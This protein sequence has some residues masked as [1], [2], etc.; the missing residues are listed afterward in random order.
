MNYAHNGSEFRYSLKRSAEIHWNEGYDP[1]WSATVDGKS[2]P[3]LK[4]DH[5][6][7]SLILPAGTHEL[8]LIYQPYPFTSAL[9]AFYLACVIALGAALSPLANL[10]KGLKP[11]LQQA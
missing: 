1:Y 4:S 2:I 11:A 8:K 5:A 9:F 7:K 3:V 10:L 6:F